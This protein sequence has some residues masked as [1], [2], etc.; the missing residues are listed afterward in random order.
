MRGGGAEVSHLRG[1][2]GVCVR[3]VS[4]RARHGRGQGIWPRGEEIHRCS[5]FG[6]FGSQVGG[7]WGLVLGNW[8]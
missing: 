7:V 6:G 1:A 2:D 3:T 5:E 4:G 8:M